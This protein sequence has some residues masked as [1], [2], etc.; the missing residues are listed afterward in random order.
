MAC[1]PLVWVSH[2]KPR[3]KDWVTGSLY[4]RS[5]QA[6]Q[7]KQRKW[8]MGGKCQKKKYVVNE[9]LLWITRTDFPWGVALG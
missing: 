3:D 5:L 8:A 2:N 9:L 6:S 7:K 4:E 1:K